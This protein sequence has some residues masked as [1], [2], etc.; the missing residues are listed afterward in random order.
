MMA[1]AGRC[2]VFDARADGFVR[3]EAAAS[4]CETLA[5][6]QAYAIRSSP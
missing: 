6:A 3:S 4:W 1:P 2:K 5:D